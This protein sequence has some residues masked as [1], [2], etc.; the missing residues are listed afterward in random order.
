MARPSKLTP[1]IRKQAYEL[2]LIGLTDKEMALAWDVS[3]STITR[4][5]QADEEFCTSLKGGKALA[6]ATVAM[7]LYQRACGYSH[8][9]EKVFMSEGKAITVKTTK[10][11]PPD[12]TACIFWLKNRQS[13][14]W[15]EKQEVQ[16]SGGGELLEM[17]KAAQ[18]K[19]SK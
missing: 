19:P 17:I 8:P 15:R 10:C 13:N 7:A 4:W 2:A 5:K 16:V 6:D 14:S 11:Y 18:H 12:T 3:E 9:E 1:E